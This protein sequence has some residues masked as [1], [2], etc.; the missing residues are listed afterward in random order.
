MKSQMRFVDISSNN[1]VLRFLDNLIVTAGYKY[2]LEYF[3]I[4]NNQKEYKAKKSIMAC[5]AAN[6]KKN[7]AFTRV[8][9]S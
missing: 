1:I 9:V 4:E 6:S 5:S 7:D 3:G 8:S 2:N